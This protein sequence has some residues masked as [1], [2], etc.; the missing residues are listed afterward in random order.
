MTSHTLA[1]LT[2]IGQTKQNGQNSYLPGLGGHVL[3]VTQDPYVPV[4][5]R[6]KI[7]LAPTTRHKRATAKL[8]RRESLSLRPDFDFDLVFKE[9]HQGLRRKRLI[10][11]EFLLSGRPNHYTHNAE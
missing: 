1:K 4:M 3:P 2:K 6:L 11:V 10:L 8:Q 9:R 5:S 7:R